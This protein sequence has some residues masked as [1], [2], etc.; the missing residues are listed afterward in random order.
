MLTSTDSILKKYLQLQYIEK[1]FSVFNYT[2]DIT[3]NHNKFQIT[4]NDF[5][6]WCIFIYIND[7]D[8]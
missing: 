8:I 1:L 2:N 7:I 5:K 3:I 6:Y 4:I